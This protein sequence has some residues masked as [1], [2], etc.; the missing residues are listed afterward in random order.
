VPRE[1]DCTAHG[2]RQ[3]KDAGQVLGSA[4]HE[5]AQLAHDAVRPLDLLRDPLEALRQE[6]AIRRPRGIRFGRPSLQRS[7]I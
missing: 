2:W 4:A 5:G 6:G 3:R 1:L 7:P